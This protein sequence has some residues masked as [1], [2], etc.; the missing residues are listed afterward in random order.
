MCRLTTLQWWKIEPPRS[1]FIKESVPIEQCNN[2]QCTLIMWLFKQL[3]LDPKREEHLIYYK[4][5]PEHHLKMSRLGGN[6]VLNILAQLCSPKIRLIW[7]KINYKLAKPCRCWHKIIKKNATEL[8]TFKK[9]RFTMITIEMQQITDI[10]LGTRS[11]LSETVGS[12]KTFRYSDLME[13]G[14]KTD[15]GKVENKVRSPILLV[16][17]NCFHQLETHQKSQDCKILNQQWV[18][19]R[20]LKIRAAKENWSLIIKK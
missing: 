5:P 3:L 12:R 7:L 17:M 18:W 9:H 14:A 16:R 8:W 2:N 20:W 10:I 4:H 6:R 11:T 13:A 19:K 15:T 1:R